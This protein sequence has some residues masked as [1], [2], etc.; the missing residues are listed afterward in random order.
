MKATLFNLLPFGR[1]F[2]M[3]NSN[4]KRLIKA[5]SVEFGLL[6]AFI[7]AVRNELQPAT[8]DKMAP[9]WRALFNTDSLDI[10]QSYFS[11]TG[12]QNITY[13][14]QQL[15]LIDADVQVQITRDQAAECGDPQSQAGAV[16]CGGGVSIVITYSGSL[17]DEQVAEL[18]TVATYYFP[19]HYV[20]AITFTPLTT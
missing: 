6:K 19:A 1:I 7:I 5:L 18:R 14:L 10:A 12:G 15:R 11:S 3:P 8:S 16:N 2:D 4:F 17:T 20:N 13:I 9:E